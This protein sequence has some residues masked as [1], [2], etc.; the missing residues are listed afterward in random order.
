MWK[1]KEPKEINLSESV[2]IA[3]ESTRQAFEVFFGQQITLGGDI[4]IKPRSI[5][6]VAE[7]RNQFRTVAIEGTYYFVATYHKAYSFTAEVELKSP[8]HGKPSTFQYWQAERA[9]LSFLDNEFVNI[10]ACPVHRTWCVA[11]WTQLSEADY[12][13]HHPT[14]KIGIEMGGA[15]DYKW[16]VGQTFAD[17]QFVPFYPKLDS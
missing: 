12:T 4:H 16:R 6:K 1:D 14:V 2:T 9:H 17:R 3:L 11:H 15:P 13:V 10:K 7:T 5:R 8:W